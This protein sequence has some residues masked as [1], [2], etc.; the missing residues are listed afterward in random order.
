ML[1]FV[2]LVSFVV[3]IEMS[4]ADYKAGF[5]T[6]ADERDFDCLDVRGAFPAWLR[7]T[8][9]RNGP[10]KFEVGEQTY[11]HWFDGLAML[12]R[13]SFADG[14]ISYANRFL[15]S[16]SFTEAAEKGRISRN[17]FATDPCQTIFGRARAIFSPT[18]NASVNLAKF[19]DAHVALTE[20][21]LPIRFD[22]NTL[23]SDFDFRFD[24]SINAHA[25]TAHPH[26]DA[27]R[28][29]A[30]SYLIRF[31]LRSEYIICRI[32][33]GTRRREAVARIPVREP[34]YM[35]T[36]AITE[37]YIVLVEFPL[38]ITPYEVITSGRPFIENY[39][40][41]PE[42]GARFVVV[43]KHD[44]SIASIHE[45]ESFFAFHH[46]NAFE[47][48]GEIVIDI[49]AYDDATIIESLYL[50]RLRASTNH[51]PET[52]LRRYTLKPGTTQSATYEILS[53][54]SIELPRI[55]YERINARPYRFVYGTSQSTPGAFPDQLV[56]L[57][58]EGGAARTWREA[59]C[60]PGEPVFISAPDSPAE[61]G[62]VILSVVLDAKAENSFL[63]LLDARD[64]RELARASV[65]H[66]IP[67]GF[68]GQFL[69]A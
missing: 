51:V 34:A 16:R 9:V 47:R 59:D 63:L 22:P 17:E 56:K 50:D 14:R 20:S 48:A 19:G 4:N 65:P 43:N 42:T 33:D 60:Y 38:R 18:D 6:L 53:D 68:H 35:H 66:T 46:V 57:D 30:W 49:C 21:V 7:G 36:F 37:R 27:K 64:F 8:L 45:A 62:G 69:A 26:H 2:S 55:D 54:T 5:R 52:R 61:D 23:E 29:E 67:H 13:F 25:T 58:T 44:G 24:D 10:A 15:R 3:K 11:R 28:K 12:H 40:W 39:R 1:T 41:Q 31:G 32:A